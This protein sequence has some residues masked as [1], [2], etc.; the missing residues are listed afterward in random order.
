[1]NPLNRRLAKL[2][3]GHDPGQ[4]P[5]RVVIDAGVSDEDAERITA[6]AIEA[7]RPEAGG[8]EIFVIQRRIVAAQTNQNTRDGSRVT[9]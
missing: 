9:C 2:E 3:R 7:A 6:N 8:R 1:M 5:I 4:Y